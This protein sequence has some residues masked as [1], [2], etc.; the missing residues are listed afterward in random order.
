MCLNTPS[1]H[2]FLPSS[3]VS[4]T[5]RISA[6]TMAERVESR[7]GK[8]FAVS[9]DFLR[10]ESKGRRF[11]RAPPGPSAGAEF[12][13]V[14]PVCVKGLCPS[15]TSKGD[16]NTGH[17]VPSPR[18]RPG[19]LLERTGD[20]PCKDNRVFP[21]VCGPVCVTPVLMNFPHSRPVVQPVCSA[22]SALGLPG[23]GSQHS[24]SNPRASFPVPLSFLTLGPASPPF[25]CRQTQKLV[26]S[27]LRTRGQFFSGPVSARAARSLC[28][29]EHRDDS[30][31]LALQPRGAG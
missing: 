31:S 30:R 1:G 8:V 18:K 27:S 20:S 24:G 11:P 2:C 5:F 7:A 16:S 4:V 29:D 21:D 15:L 10:D 23:A 6:F 13:V 12:Q 25:G 22:P 9:L 14:F 19:W 3:L 17:S 26:S 28:S